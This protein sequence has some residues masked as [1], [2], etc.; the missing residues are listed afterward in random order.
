[1][2]RE[3]VSMSE[4]VNLQELEVSDAEIHQ[5]GVRGAL[6]QVRRKWHAYPNAL[7]AVEMHVARRASRS[8]LRRNSAPGWRRL[9]QKQGA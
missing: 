2:R 7:R 6:I 3:T 8:G 9:G 1:M 5:D 4:F